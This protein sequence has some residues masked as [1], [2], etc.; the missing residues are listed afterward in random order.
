M[1]ETITTGS[2]AIRERYVVETGDLGV[3]VTHDTVDETGH[4]EVASTAMLLIDPE[5]MPEVIR[6]LQRAQREAGDHA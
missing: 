1:I 2:G 6:A 4:V 5:A 3:Y